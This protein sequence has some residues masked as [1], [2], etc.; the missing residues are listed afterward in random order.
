MSMFQCVC[1]LIPFCN[2]YSIHLIK[3][4]SIRKSL[5]VLFRILLLYQEI[6]LHG[7][8]TLS[9]KIRMEQF[10][11]SRNRKGE[12]IAKQSTI[13]AFPRHWN[14]QVLEYS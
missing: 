8:I 6:V 9:K 5:P 3:V 2:T 4:I 7:E 1:P 10:I 13:R 12:E 11:T 14:G